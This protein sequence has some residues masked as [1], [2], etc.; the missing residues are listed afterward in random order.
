MHGLQ[1]S[2]NDSF[3][4][5]SKQIAALADLPP[6]GTGEASLIMRTDLGLHFLNRLVGDVSYVRNHGTSAMHPGRGI[7]V[8][9]HTGTYP[10]FIFRRQFL[11][12]RCF[13]AQHMLSHQWFENHK[14]PARLGEV[15]GRSL[16]QC[17]KWRAPWI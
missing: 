15:N 12:V 16:N 1:E 4:K 3:N 2:E 7:N 5:G 11:D 14:C 8:S 9:V 13:T 6:I 17:P 10:P